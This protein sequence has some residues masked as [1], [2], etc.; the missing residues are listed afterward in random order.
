MFP[1]LAV[2]EFAF[3]RD[4]VGRYA[5]MAASDAMLRVH[6]Q[7]FLARLDNEE[8]KRYV[9]PAANSVPSHAPVFLSF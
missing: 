9:F 6:I 1:V 8:K 5:T 4:K 2:L 3:L 7:T